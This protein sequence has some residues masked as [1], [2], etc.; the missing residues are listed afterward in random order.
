MG[1]GQFLPEPLAARIVPLM[2]ESMQRFNP[3]ASWACAVSASR[4]YDMAPVIDL[5][6]DRMPKGVRI[7]PTDLIN[8]AAFGSALHKISRLREKV[9]VV[10]FGGY[11]GLHRVAIATAFP[12]LELEWTV[13][14]LPR[15]VEVMKNKPSE[16]PL[17]TSDLEM[18]LSEG[19]D[20]VLASASL[21]YV[22]TPIDVLQQFIS[23]SQFVFLNRLPLWPVEEHQVAVQRAQRRPVEISYPTW[24]FSRKTFLS[25]LPFSCDI[26]MEIEVSS[27]RAFFA[28]HYGTYSGLLIESGSDRATD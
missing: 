8:V 13:V 19:V 24:F 10:D 21:N 28:G 23:H 17:F 6:Q 9:R 12:T 18:A 15:V 1:I 20:F 5:H 25:G 7:G 3:A 14:E 27:D 22:H 26:R 4:G 11:L 2:P 16:G